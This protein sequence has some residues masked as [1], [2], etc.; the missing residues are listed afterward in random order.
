MTPIEVAAFKA[1][2]T[3]AIQTPRL[4]TAADFAA[5]GAGDDGQGDAHRQ[6]GIAQLQ[7]AVVAEDQANA[8]QRNAPP[9]ERS[10]RPAVQHPTPDELAQCL[11]HAIKSS[12]AT[13][14]QR[15]AALET[16]LAQLRDQV[17]DLQA[18]RAAREDPVAP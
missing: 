2:F 6:W 17:V 15:I 12:L 10:S 8:H 13:P 5:L 9:A 3:K 18:E 1:A 7:K 16:E 11:V 14:L 4:L